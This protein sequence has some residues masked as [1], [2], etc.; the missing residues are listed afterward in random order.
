VQTFDMNTSDVV[1]D[2]AQPGHSFQPFRYT[3]TKLDE[4]RVGVWLLLTTWLGTYKWDVDEGL[5]VEAIQDPITSD[6]EAGELVADVVL[7]YPG[8]E[9]ITLG[10]TVTRSDAGKVITIDVEAQT[11]AGTIGFAVPVP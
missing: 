6:A 7:S 9:R 3:Q 11:V 10:P 8:V 5:D 4:I 2:G 1:V